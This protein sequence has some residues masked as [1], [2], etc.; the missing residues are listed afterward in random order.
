MDPWSI[1]IDTLFLILTLLLIPSISRT[2]QLNVTPPD[3]LLISPPATP[4]S[5]ITPA[6]PSSSH[7]SVPGVDMS[8]MIPCI[9]F[10]PDVPEIYPR[11]RRSSFGSLTKRFGHKRKSRPK[12]PSPSLSSANSQPGTPIPVVVG[13]TGE[14]MAED[15]T[16]RKD[17]E[18]AMGVKKKWL[19]P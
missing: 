9:T 2:P 17:V 4:L 10:T 1:S 7:L 16:H 12:S 11:H 3:D 8:S 19:M 6:S 15:M 18:D 14:V 5:P 13:V